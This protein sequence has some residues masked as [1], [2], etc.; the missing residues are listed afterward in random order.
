[1]WLR[2]V[3]GTYMEMEYQQRTGLMFAGGRLWRWL[4]NVIPIRPKLTSTGPVGTPSTSTPKLYTPAA[5]IRVQLYMGI[6]GAH[7][8][9]AQ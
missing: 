1:M 2:T 8:C 7:G 4:W 5:A 3:Q 9:H 6:T